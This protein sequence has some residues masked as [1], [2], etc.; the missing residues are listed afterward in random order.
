MTEVSRI[1][2][3]VIPGLRIGSRTVSDIHAPALARRQSR[4]GRACSASTACS[5]Q[6]V[7]FDFERQEMTISPSRAR[8]ERWPEGTIV[9]TGRSRFGRLVLVDAAVDGQRVWVIVDTG[10]QVT[11][12]N[13]ALRGALA[14]RG[15]LGPTAPIELISITGGRIDRRI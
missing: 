12:A 1:A 11:V 9:V 14:R 15:R 8:E 13:T 7:V 4:R 6:R 5:A 10:S 3:V 2:T